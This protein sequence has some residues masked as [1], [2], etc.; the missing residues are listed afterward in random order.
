LVAKL[1]DVAGTAHGVRH[2]LVDGLDSST[3]IAGTHIEAGSS[4]CQVA[5]ITASHGRETG[6]RSRKP[7][8]L[9]GGCDIWG[10]KAAAWSLSLP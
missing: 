3:G 5:H 6:A 4:E 2:M 7:A 8:N 9:T 10:D 1:S